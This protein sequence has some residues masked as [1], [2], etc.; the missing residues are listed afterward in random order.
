MK[1][2]TTVA[3]PS[4]RHA[5]RTTSGLGSGAAALTLAA[6]SWS[7]L[8]AP[9][10]HACRPSSPRACSPPSPPPPQGYYLDL[11]AAHADCGLLVQEGSEGGDYAYAFASLAPWKVRPL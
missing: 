11:L 6:A 10:A 2:T 7:G 4:P 9:P 8:A 3:A 5:E 1:R